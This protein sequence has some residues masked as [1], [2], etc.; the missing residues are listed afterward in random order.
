M[1]AHVITR[2]KEGAV[3][4]ETMVSSRVL[5]LVI[6]AG[7]MPLIRWLQKVGDSDGEVLEELCTLHLLYASYCA[8]LQFGLS[9]SFRVGAVPVALAQRMAPRRLKLF[10]FLA[11]LD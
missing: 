10:F 9:G 7:M 1:S 5:C 3:E 11:E 8:V 6:I 4:D 2:L